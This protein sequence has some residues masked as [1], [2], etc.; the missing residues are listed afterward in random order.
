M[1]HVNKQAAP[2]PIVLETLLNGFKYKEGWKASLRE[3]DRG[4]GCTGLTLVILIVQPDTYHPER[5]VHVNH[6]FAVPP[7]AYDGRSWRRWLFDRILDV[8]KHEAMEF[9]QIDGQRPY[10]PNHGPGN[11]PYTVFEIG[12]EQEKRTSYLGVTRPQPDPDSEEKSR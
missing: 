11:D 3:V 7:A 1:D 10:A 8:E 12:T 6:S 4:Q 9:F 5:T 2:Y